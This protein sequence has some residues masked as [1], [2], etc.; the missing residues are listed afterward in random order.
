MGRALVTKV[1]AVEIKT[2]GLALSLE[3]Q[4]CTIIMK[5]IGFQKKESKMKSWLVN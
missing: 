4:E 1:K 3:L 2:S 5:V